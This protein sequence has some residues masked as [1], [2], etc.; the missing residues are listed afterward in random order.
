[1]RREGATEYSPRNRQ[2]PQRGCQDRA[3]H[4]IGTYQD[5]LKELVTRSQCVQHQIKR[6]S[7]P[8]RFETASGAR[9]R[10]R[11]VATRKTAPARYR[12]L[13]FVPFVLRIGISLG[14]RATAQ[15]DVLG[16]SC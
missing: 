4:R 12:R 16:L 13:G 8:F 5:L 3:T 6:S 9:Y 15:R 14:V 11:T 1:G 2:P 7:K 10:R